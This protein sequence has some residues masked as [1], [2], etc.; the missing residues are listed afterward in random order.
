MHAYAP[1]GQ[2]LICIHHLHIDFLLY[3]HIGIS[4]VIS[5]FRGISSFVYCDF[6]LQAGPSPSTWCRRSSPEVQADTDTS[7]G[8][9]RRYGVVGSPIMTTLLRC[10]VSNDKVCERPSK[11]RFLVFFSVC[12]F[13]HATKN[14]YVLLQ[15]PRRTLM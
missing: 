8:P 15:I 14:L 9:R 3:A 5:Y 1:L 12:F 4:L 7:R 13:R 2:L 6:L 11:F 10:H